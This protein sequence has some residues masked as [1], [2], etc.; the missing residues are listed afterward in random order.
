MVAVC[1]LLLAL[2]S[3]AMPG[4]A[5]GHPASAGEPD[6]LFRS[7][8][9]SFA[10]GDLHAAHKAFARL[11]KLLPQAGVAHS[12]YGAVLLAE[13]DT[14]LAVTELREAQRLDPMDAPAAVNLGVALRR[15][16]D[17]TGAVSAF[18]SAGGVPLQPDEAVAYGS[19]LASTGDLPRAEAVLEGALPGATG[20]TQR[21]ALLDALGA[22]LAQQSKLPE[23][24]QRFQQ[25]LAADAGFAPAHAHLGS[26]L[27]LSGDAAGGFRELQQAEQLGDHSTVTLVQL[28]RAELANGRDHEAE[29]VA[30]R[31]LAAAPDDVDAQ[32][33]L[34]LALQSLGDSPAA[35]PLF[36]GVALKRTGDAE[37]LTNYGLALVQTGK[38]KEALQ[39][40]DR[41][42]AA[43]G[44]VPVLRENMGAAYIQQNDIDHAMEQFRAGLQA[45]PENIQLH[46]DL[47]LAY[48]LKDDVPA[49]T[50]E[51]QHAQQLDPDLPDAA[52]TLGV[53]EMQQGHFD[54]AAT[55]L[56]RVVRLQPENGDAF[57]L[58]GS[59]Y[60]QSHHPEQAT[61]ALRRAIALLPAQPSSHVMLA[62][63]LAEAGDRQ[64]AAAERKVAADL[65]RA[66]V[67][68]QRAQFAL[69]SG[70]KLLEQ[71]KL[72]GALTQA[73]VA[74]E[75]EPNSAASHLLLAEVLQR[76]GKVVEAGVERDTAAS[77]SA[78]LSPQ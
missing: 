47:G 70:R 51:L 38:A 64:G 42:L 44:A 15:A 4:Q 56:E 48:K 33:E 46:Y 78:K 14:N 3:G 52:Y 8:S 58:L 9:A 62:S 30:R 24:Q 59:V 2:G 27:L 31:A 6:R 21:A 5:A 39:V 22:V 16:G 11:V 75:A 76:A 10:A 69:E 49:A 72:D 60:Q 54:Q 57:S 71:G 45:D 55:Q 77:I 7:G 20:V 53:L 36:T 18:R 26:A 66:A 19:A 73:R 61:A 50:R 67:S 43:G 29:A 17:N 68:H 23:A 40:Y 28:A 13:G 65:S 12:A 41:A 74:V 25:A 32:Y 34:A 63:V 37:V 1:G 35:L